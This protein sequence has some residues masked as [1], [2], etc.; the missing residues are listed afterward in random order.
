MG[1][2][3]KANHIFALFGSTSFEGYSSDCVSSVSCD[4]SSVLS[5]FHNQLIERLVYEN[6]TSTGSFHGRNI[7]KL[8]CSFG[9]YVAKSSWKRLSNNSSSN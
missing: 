3:Q 5:F 7:P 1:L 9:G 2:F 6:I 8:S 4:S